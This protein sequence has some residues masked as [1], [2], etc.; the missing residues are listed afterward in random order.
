MTVEQRKSRIED[1]HRWMNAVVDAA[2]RPTCRD[3]IEILSERTLRQSDRAVVWTDFS[4][5]DAKPKLLAHGLGPRLVAS[6][7]CG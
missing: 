3:Q 1:L 7:V 6:I 5:G 4:N 2:R